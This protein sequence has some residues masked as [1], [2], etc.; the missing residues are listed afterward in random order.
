MVD[1][2]VEG[3][4]AFAATMLAHWSPDPPIA[5]TTDRLD[6]VVGAVHKQ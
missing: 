6:Y 3:D 4:V 2:S 1:S 5:I